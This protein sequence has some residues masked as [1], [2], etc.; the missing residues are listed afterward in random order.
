VRRLPSAD[1]Y[2]PHGRPKEAVKGNINMINKVQ[3]FVCSHENKTV[4]VNSTIY[5][6]DGRG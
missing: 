6:V 4:L 1:K 3:S 5:L 2:Q